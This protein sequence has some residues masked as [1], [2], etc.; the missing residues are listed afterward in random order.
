MLDVDVVF[1]IQTIDRI[2]LIN[3]SENVLALTPHWKG[4]GVFHS[5]FIKKC[6]SKWYIIL[7]YE[8]SD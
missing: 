7:V 2:I 4:T 6:T 1:R 5:H 8:Q 3:Y